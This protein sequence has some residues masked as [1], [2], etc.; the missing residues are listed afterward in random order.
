MVYALSVQFCWP[1]FKS[2]YAIDV[3]TALGIFLIFL[4]FVLYFLFDV[5]LWPIFIFHI[6]VSAWVAW[7]PHW[8]AT[9]SNIKNIHKFCEWKTKIKTV[10]LRC[11]SPRTGNAALVLK[12]AFIDLHWKPCCYFGTSLWSRRFLETDRR[13]K[14]LLFKQLLHQSRLTWIFSAHIPQIYMSITLSSILALNH[15]GYSLPPYLP[16][17]SFSDSAVFP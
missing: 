7:S 6:L 11:A 4:Y 9:R 13:S 5:S 3:S 17:F 8:G 2:G 16:H 10:E 14:Y 1:F 12:L 15:P